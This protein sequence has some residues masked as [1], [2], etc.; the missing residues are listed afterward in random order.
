MIFHQIFWIMHYVLWQK[1]R[2]RIMKK[3]VKHG[4]AFSVMPVRSA[5]SVAVLIASNIYDGKFT[6]RKSERERNFPLSFI[7]VAHELVKDKVVCVWVLFIANV[8]NENYYCVV[9]CTLRL[10]WN[11][12]G[13]SGLANLKK[14]IFKT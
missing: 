14:L 1:N 5:M 7:L 4:R 9:L 6:R 12:S 10:C 8:K 2:L 11:K 13:S 3:N